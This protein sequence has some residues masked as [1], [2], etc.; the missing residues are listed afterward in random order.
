MRRTFFFAA[1]AALLLAIPL[2]AGAAKRA[3]KQ[4]TYVVLYERG[5]STA[6]ARAAI[7]A[8]GGRLVEQNAKV[9]V[10]TVRS[11]NANFV[12]DVSRT[13]AVVGAARNRPVGEAPATRSATRSRSS[14]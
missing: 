13:R 8:A 5:A 4:H 9:G 3:A 6:D 1:V 2:T 7:K 14:A 12:A 10:A 11:A